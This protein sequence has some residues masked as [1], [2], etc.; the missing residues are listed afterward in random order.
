MDLLP[1][2]FDMMVYGKCM[3][4]IGLYNRIVFDLESLPTVMPAIVWACDFVKEKFP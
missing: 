2:H 1:R 3:R 4:V